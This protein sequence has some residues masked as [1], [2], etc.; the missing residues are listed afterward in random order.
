MTSPGQ[1]QK[2]PSARI[3]LG[4]RQPNHCLAGAYAFDVRRTSGILYHP[5]EG[6]SHT[7]V[8]QFD[9]VARPSLDAVT[10]RRRLHSLSGPDAPHHD[11]QTAE[12]AMVLYVRVRGRTAT[13]IPIV[14]PAQECPLAGKSES[15]NPGLAPTFKPLHTRT[16]RAGALTECRRAL[17]PRARRRPGLRC[18]ERRSSHIPHRDTLGGTPSAASMRRRSPT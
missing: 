7:L 8:R 10:G 16:F 13:G 14:T 4:D 12:I 1:A 11:G 3:S 6:D 2:N 17:A 15:G 18:F 9:G 5:V